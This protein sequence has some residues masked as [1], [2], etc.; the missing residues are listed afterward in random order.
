ML[1]D[2][3]KGDVITYTTLVTTTQATTMIALVGER[4]LEELGLD[5]W[6]DCKKSTLM[7]T[8]DFE[9]Y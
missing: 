8:T 3:K 1:E 7:S 4:I 2:R 5:L 6:H 9:R